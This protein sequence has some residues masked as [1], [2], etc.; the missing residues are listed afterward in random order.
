M[1]RSWHPRH[2]KSLKMNSF[3]LIAMDVNLDL[4]ALVYQSGG[5]LKLK[6]IDLSQ[7][8]PTRR[9]RFK[10]TGIH[11]ESAPAGPATPTIRVTKNWIVYVSPRFIDIWSRLD[12]AATYRLEGVMENAQ[13]VGDMILIQTAEGWEQW[14]IEESNGCLNVKSVREAA[15]GGAHRRWVFA[16]DLKTV[17]DL[18][19]TKDDGEVLTWSLEEGPPKALQLLDGETGLYHVADR[20]A[21]RTLWW[22]NG[23]CGMRQ[24][25]DPEVSSAWP[26]PMAGN[27]PL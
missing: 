27:R 20:A 21:H 23:T 25:H 19:G 24:V 9:Q 12:M 1:L 18:G 5:Y 11:V 22:R 3:P 17:L 16:Q 6:L 26:P 8:I 2:E 15:A 4:L 10:D 14:R 13:V 7:P